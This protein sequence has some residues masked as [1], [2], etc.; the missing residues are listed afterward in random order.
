MADIW[1]FAQADQPVGPMP[2]AD[3]KTA[4][5]LKSDART[6]LVWQPSFSNWK[7]AEDVPELVA[8]V[9]KPPPIKPAEIRPPPF[10]PSEAA[11]PSA[12][13]ESNEKTPKQL[14][15]REA[16]L[17]VDSKHIR[18]AAQSPA[19]LVRQADRANRILAGLTVAFVG[20]MAWR[21]YLFQVTLDLVRTYGYG[22]VPQTMIP[23]GLSE[24]DMIV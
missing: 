6:V 3:L 22:H 17:V 24:S 14:K 19:Q 2:L 10:R 5:S 16:F 4:L 12:P 8:V 7:K 1:Y 15:E 23:Q 20:C 9:I 13:K 21:I 18:D 11:A